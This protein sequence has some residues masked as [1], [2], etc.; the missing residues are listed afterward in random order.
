MPKRKPDSNDYFR[1][2]DIGS[3]T[4]QPDGKLLT[5]ARRKGIPQKHQRK[6]FPTKKDAKAHLIRAIGQV[7]LK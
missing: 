6:V 7:L 5:D 2:T 1:I 4:K 3:A